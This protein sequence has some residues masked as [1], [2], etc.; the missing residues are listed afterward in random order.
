MAR[1]VELRAKSAFSFL[2]GA[3][4][5]EDLVSAAADAGMQTLAL[6]DRDGLYGAPRFYQAAR[7]AGIRPLVGADLE[8]AQGGRLLLVVKNRR[9]YKNL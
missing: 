9:G 3:S 6:C 1:Y 2:F 7:E 8:L 4:D 5:P